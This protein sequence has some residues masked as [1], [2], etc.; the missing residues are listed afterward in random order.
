M[1]AVLVRAS[2]R[3]ANYALD[4]NAGALGFLDLGER[5]AHAEDNEAD[6]EGEDEGAEEEE[7]AGLAVEPVV[8]VGRFPDAV[9]KA[10]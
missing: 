7:K 8:V 5:P 9:A 6:R 3:V 1:P 4:V 10:Q 2:A